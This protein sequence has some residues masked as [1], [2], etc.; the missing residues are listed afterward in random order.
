VPP[1]ELSVATPLGLGSLQLSCF[2]LRLPLTSFGSSSFCLEFSLGL[3]DPLQSAG[4]PLQFHG[5]FIA[6]IALA[7]LTVFLGVDDLGLAQQ[8]PHLRLELSNDNLVEGSRQT[9]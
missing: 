8:R 2:C 6:P 7:V 1:A 9:G 3:A 5:Q 4:T